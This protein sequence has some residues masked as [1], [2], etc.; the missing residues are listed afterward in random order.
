MR[1][2][3]S[4]YKSF[5]KMEQFEQQI[6]TALQTKFEGVDAKILGRIAKKKAKTATS[7]ADVKTI[8]DGITLQQVIESHADYRATEA[9][10]TAVETYENEHNLKDGKP[11]GNAGQTAGQ[12]GQQAAA[13]TAGQGEQQNNE[14][15]PAWA[16]KMMDDNQRLHEE[17]KSYKAERT[18]NTRLEACKSAIVKAPVRIRARY[19]R[20]FSRLQFKDDADF[21]SYLEEIKPDIDAI[22]EDAASKG[23]T[24]GSPLGG[25][26]ASGQAS[27][28]VKARFAQPTTAAP[29]S[30]AI[31]GLPTNPTT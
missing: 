13:Q 31:A 26:A 16:Q 28:L 7:E 18:A 21:E 6:L 25:G 3:K 12:G 30:P 27:E 11:K 14:V 9:R 2:N 8:V 17:L 15:V 20:D 23:G 22:A 10:R 1:V 4:N 24:V 5:C 29:V 19:E